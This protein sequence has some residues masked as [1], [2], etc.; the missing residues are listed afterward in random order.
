MKGFF[1]LS[2]T[3]RLHWT[4]G[5][6]QAHDLGLMNT[7]CSTNH[8]QPGHKECMEVS[9]R[10]MWRKVYFPL[11]MVKMISTGASGCTSS[12][13]SPRGPFTDAVMLVP[14][15]NVVCDDPIDLT[16]EL[17]VPGLVAVLDNPSKDLVQE[18]DS[19]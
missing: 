10:F 18:S 4:L 6:V 17:S 19:V 2:S 3:T 16:S 11:H 13:P 5:F 7:C 1:L 8:G 9:L 12:M 14:D 15:S